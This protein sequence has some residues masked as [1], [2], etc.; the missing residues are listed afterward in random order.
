MGSSRQVK[1]RP[2]RWREDLGARD[3]QQGSQDVTGPRAHRAEARWPPDPRRSRRSTVSAW[4]SSVWATA[5]ATACSWRMTVAQEGV[6]FA[7]RGVL[8]TRPRPEG[9]GLDVGSA[10]PERHAQARAELLAG[11]RVL[12]GPGPQAM[13]EMRGHQ[14]EGLPLGEPGERVQKGG[15][16]GPPG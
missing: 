5:I 4:S 1:P 14:A 2:A 10:E 9:V 6:A 13:V 12:R 7:P 8:E 15:R 3:A 11:G 16:I